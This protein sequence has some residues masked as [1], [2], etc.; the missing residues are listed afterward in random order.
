MCHD[1][2]CGQK[3]S[4]ENAHSVMWG[5][6]LPTLEAWGVVLRPHLVSGKGWKESL[7]SGVEKDEV[8]TRERRTPH[9]WLTICR[10]GWGPQHGKDHQQ[11]HGLQLE[12]LKI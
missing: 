8:A 11:Q 5:A 12:H 9:N 2:L 3:P 10:K 1:N 4:K 6:C 7:G